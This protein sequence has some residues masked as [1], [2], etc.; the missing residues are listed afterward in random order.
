MTFPKLTVQGRA[1]RLRNAMRERELDGFVVVDLPSVRWLTGFTG[2][3]GLAVISAKDVVLATDGR[4]AT[5]APAQLEAAGSD[6]TVVIAS[7]LVASGADV[8]RGAARVALEGDVISWDQQRQWAA[9]LAGSELVAVSGLLR[10]LRS[11]KD[12][13]E[14]ARIEAAAAL[15]DAALADTEVLRAPGTTERQLGLALD[16]AMRAAGATGP[17]YETI[18]ASGPNAALPHARPSDRAFEVGDL[19]IVDVGALVDGYRSDMTRSFVIGGPDAAD[20]VARKILPLVTEAQ[21]AA[22]AVVAPG[23]EAKAVDDA[24]RS[25]IAEAGFGDAFRHGTGHGVG[26]DIHE[27]P[28]I[29]KDNAAIL[30]AGQVLTVEPGVYLPDVGGVRVE[31]LVVVTDSGC[32][33]LTLS[34]KLSL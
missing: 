33:P 24:C 29:R 19:L 27:L 10:E 18:V 20:D 31:D 15:A 21:A 30:Q 6:A 1:D 13:A 17:A 7:D 25:I 3:N 2:S 34:P 28:S 16:D 23:V 9:A 22:V 11:V 8:L 4:Y 32:R 14:L 12:P 26:L 5:Q